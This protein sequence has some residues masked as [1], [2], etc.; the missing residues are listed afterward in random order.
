MQITNRK[1]LSEHLES[2]MT[3][4]QERL[5]EEGELDYNQF[6]LKT[7][8]IESSVSDLREIKS[9]D[10]YNIQIQQTD[11]ITLHILKVRKNS[12]T[13]T[14]YVDTVNPRYWLIH[15]VGSY[16]FTNPFI[17]K[18]VTS[19]M[20]GLDHLWLP[21]NFMM[22]LSK[23]DDFRGFSLKYDEEFSFIDDKKPV[24]NLSMK[25]WGGAAPHVLQALK[26]DKDLKNTIAISGIGIKHSANGGF[27]IDDVTAWGKFTAKGTSIDD[28]YF[29][30][31]DVQTRY[32]EKINLIENAWLDYSKDNIGIRFSG[33]PLTIIFN[34]K[35]E[36]IPD[37]I[38]ELLASRK[39]FRL[40]GLHKI[41]NDYFAKVVGIDL[42]TGHKINL[43]I[44][45]EWIRIY[46]PKGSC[47]NTI[48]RL[49]TNIQHHY[50]SE[51]TLESGEHGRII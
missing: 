19:V 33:E 6:L 42:H 14:F 3:S 7:Y 36:N 25:L 13:A 1:E 27:A 20:S 4:S 28:H 17:R 32:S 31:K 34:K 16:K 15:G 26:R 23:K 18:Y 10:G 51:A 8:L 29:V 48:L 24:E 22:E 38:N 47:G 39:P 40:W 35:I 50:D 5:E 46:L 45:N 21:N 12:K 11:D 9:P 41:L 49:L 44:T 37:F 43:D 2:V 30:V